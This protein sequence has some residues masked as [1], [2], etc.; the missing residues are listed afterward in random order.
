MARA[1]VA[2]RRAEATARR[3]RERVPA[4]PE[5]RPEREERRGAGRLHRRLAGER[6][7]PDGLAAARRLDG[8][9]DHAHGGQDDAGELGHGR[10][11][12]GGDADGEGD[13]R[14]WWR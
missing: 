7:G 13:E 2:P 12:A 14:R 4:S 1:L 3:R 9:E 8:H 10:P 11:L 6:R 5:A